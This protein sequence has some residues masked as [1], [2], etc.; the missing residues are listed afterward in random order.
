MKNT[1]FISVV[2]GAAFLFFSC[3]NEE[4]P[5]KTGTIEFKCINPFA[6]MLAP[7]M[8]AVRAAF[9]N[10]PLTGDTT[11]THMLSMRWVIGD[12]WVAQGEVKAGETD[13]LEWIRLT[14]TTNREMKLFEEYTFAPQTVPVGDY[15]SV[16]ITFRNI[17]YRHVRLITDPE[18][19]YELL[20]TMGSWTDPCNAADTSWAATNYFSTGG[21][22]ILNDQGRFVLA[23]EGEKI[24]GLSI[25]ENKKAIVSWRLGAGASAP[26]INYLIDENGN[27]QWDCGVDRVE[28]E[29]P[30]DMEYMWD[31]VVEY[32]D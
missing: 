8:V 23:S 31:F 3:N 12:V 13:N 6:D 21:N 15:Q 27:R 4:T 7:S 22:H 26:C 29:C 9:E 20:E 25:L 14:T 18:V 30:A 19:A 5:E 32:E 24:S 17:F 10:P 11:A 16:K 2:L 1:F 28:D